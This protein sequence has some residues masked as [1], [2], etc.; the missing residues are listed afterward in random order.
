MFGIGYEEQS[1]HMEAGYAY[2]FDNGNRHWV[3]NNSSEDRVHLIIDTV[4]AP[5]LFALA[6]KAHI[7]TAERGW[8]KPATPELPDE[9]MLV[10]P[11]PHADKLLRL[12]YEDWVDPN[13][14][15]VLPPATL[16]L[17]LSLSYAHTRA[18]SLSL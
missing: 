8:V 18:R 6:N 16:S 12:V 4:G 5:K 3:E 11:D 10:T 14:F 2:L 9:P 7:F 1:I 13:A 17:S 15:E